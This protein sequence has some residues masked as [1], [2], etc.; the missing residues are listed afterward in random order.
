VEISALWFNAVM[1]C[2]EL[3]EKA[4]DTKFT[5]DW[6]VLPSLIQKSFLE[7]F[8]DESKGYLADVVNDNF[9]DWSVRPNMVVATSLIYSP[10]TNEMKK[11]ILDKISSEL[12]TPRGLRTLSPKSPVY[13][14]VYEGNQ[15]SRDKAYHQGTVWPWLLE[16]YC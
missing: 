3:A 16:H 14:G 4:G 7:T 10:L 11:S 13:K 2:L 15:D 5:D 12:L 8:W 9:K 1:F 6:K